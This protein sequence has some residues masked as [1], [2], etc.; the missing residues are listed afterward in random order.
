M[1]E[2]NIS[3]WMDP[4]EKKLILDSLDSDT[5]MMEWGSGGSTLEFSSM[6]DR[7]YSIEHNLEWYNKISDELKK[8][9]LN[10]VDYRYVAQNHERTGE[11]Q[12]TYREFK[13][14][15]DEVDN[16]NEKFDVVL[17]DGRARRLC[18]KKVIPYLKEDSVL[19]IHDYVLRRAYWPVED[20]FEIVEAVTDTVQT[21]AKFKL[22][23]T[24][25]S[26]A[27]DLD[28]GSTERLY[29]EGYTDGEARHRC[30]ARGE[31]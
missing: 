22:R 31:R 10:D 24:F 21:I 19:F 1:D 25:A 8:Y 5:V 12:S 3:T 16:F 9:P 23:N 17:I 11:G 18:A 15:I 26:D 13:D 20:Y 29:E 4:R 2:N 7:Y 6:V 28:L 14:Y 27:Y 30:S